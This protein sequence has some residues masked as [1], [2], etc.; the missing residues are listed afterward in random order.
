MR[1]ASRASIRSAASL[2]NWTSWS[3]TSSSCGARWWP[4]ATS[5]SIKANRKELQMP[6]LQDLVIAYRLLA[7][8]GII[9]AYGH[10]SVRSPSNPERSLMARSIAP[11]LVTEADMM[12]FGMDSEPIDAKGFTPVTERYI[13]G[14]IY[15]SRPEV[16][17]VVHNHS[18]SVIPFCCTNT[19]LKPIFHMSA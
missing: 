3:N 18:P 14:E 1:W 4:R 16:M 12:E 2:K 9:D 13:H 6:L 15:K 19:G 8:H 11:E 7:D 17:A 10:I 5:F